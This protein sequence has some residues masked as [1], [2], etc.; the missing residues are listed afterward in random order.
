[1]G[2][3]YK[4]HGG[5]AAGL[6]AVVLALA[7]L[8]WVPGA[9]PLFEPQWPMLAAFAMAFLA[10]ASALARIALVRAGKHTLGQ[11]FRCL[12]GGVRAGL[13]ALIVAGVAMTVF[14]M[15]ESRGLQQP[16]ERDGRYFAVD[17]VS[18]ARETVEV[19]KSRYQALKVSDRRG[20]F[21]TLGVLIVGASCA[22]LAA[23]EVRRADRGPVVPE[24]DTSGT[25]E[26]QG[27][28]FPGAE[29]LNPS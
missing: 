21:T 3:T 8:A 1:M 14:D 6:G 12:P 20:P 19:S 24:P 15:V 16:E 9:A 25:S 13:V 29:P 5:V 7:A 26:T 10:M 22:V 18:R 17:T 23:G 11:A 4:V 27:V 2:W 28:P